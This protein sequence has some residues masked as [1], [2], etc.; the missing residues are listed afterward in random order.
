MPCWARVSSLLRVRQAR[1][2]SPLRISTV[3]RR[4]LASCGDSW[5]GR[6]GGPALV[7]GL[8]RAINESISDTR[9]ARRRAR[10][11]RQRALFGYLPS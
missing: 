2:R 11:C 6:C 9:P 8:L 1:E 4:V 10:R 5:D 3:A 7:A